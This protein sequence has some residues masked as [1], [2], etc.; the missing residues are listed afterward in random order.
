MFLVGRA[1]AG[2]PVL[3]STPA[4]LG[5]VDGP[6]FVALALALFIGYQL[7]A[8][9]LVSSHEP[10]PLRAII[11]IVWCLGLTAV[12]HKRALRAVLRPRVSIA[13][14]I[15]LGLLVLLASLPLVYGL[16]LAMQQ[17]GSSDVQPQVEWM[18]ERK[19]GWQWMVVLAV[20]VAPIVEEVGFRG[21]LFLGLRRLAGPR[22]AL[23]LSSVLFG[24][25]HAQPN[26][27]APLAVFGVF[28]AYLVEV[29]GSL[30]P[31]IVAHMAF[32]GMT[33]ALALWS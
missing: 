1:L 4:P 24:L 8:A 23:V 5:A 3:P 31:G 7:G 10:D 6:A 2:R 14:R 9:L 18:T 11:A 12:F 33:T 30:L 15:W 16:S 25:V 19:A 20:V 21:L 27:I 22:V 29:T 32:N 17:F 26:V 28:L 13:A